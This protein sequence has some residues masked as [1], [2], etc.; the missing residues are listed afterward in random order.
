M[1]IISSSE[2]DPLNPFFVETTSSMSKKEAIFASV[3]RGVIGN[4]GHSS[5]PKTRMGSRVLF[6]FVCS[7]KSFGGGF[8]PV[9]DLK[10]LNSYMKILPFKME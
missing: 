7:T 9:L 2:Q 5:R 10:V 1:D 6:P 4:K 8:R 3:C